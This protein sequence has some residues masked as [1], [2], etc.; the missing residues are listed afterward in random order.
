MSPGRLVSPSLLVMVPLLACGG[1]P[2]ASAVA[3]APAPASPV[4]SVA[5][6]PTVIFKELRENSITTLYDGFGPD[7]E[8]VEQDFGFSTI[9]RYKDKIIL[10]DAGTNADILKKNAEAL[11]VDLRT[12]DFAIASHNHFDHVSGFDYLLELNPGVKFYFPKD[13]FAGAPWEMGVEGKDPSVIAG[14]D[15]DQRYFKGDKKVHVHRSSGRFWKATNIEWVDADIEIE[16]GINLVVNRAESMGRFS[17]AGDEVKTEGE[18]E[19]SLQLAGPQGDTLMV[20]C[21]HANVDVIAETAKKKLGREIALVMGGFHLIPREA[22]EIRAL[23]EKLRNEL[24]IKRVAPAHCTGHLGFQIFGEVF[25]GAYDKA[26][27][28]RTISM[29]H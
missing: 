29:P 28:G 25:A 21:S 6:E 9:V 19:I 13:V 11:G 8:G 5:S 20:G 12:V 26:G 15:K 18:L 2:A 10:F 23:A 22:A 1:A 17:R 27:L 4:D 16:P 3:P 14:L 7:V 24:G